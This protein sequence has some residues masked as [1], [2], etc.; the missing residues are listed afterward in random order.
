MSSLAPAS[1]DDARK[2]LD[3]LLDLMV[4][5]RASDMHLSEGCVPYLRVEGV[6]RPLDE[7]PDYSVRDL[8]C[9]IVSERQRRIFDEL[10]SLD[11]AYSRRQTRYR[12]NVFQ[13]RG[14][15][16]VAIR[17][18]ENEF[19][20]LDEWGL[21]LQLASFA[22]LRDGLVIVTGPTGSGKTT[23]LA[24]LIHE[25]NLNRSC[26]IVTIEDPLE[27]VHDNIH[28]LVHQREV[29]TD[30][31]DFASAVRASLRED[32]DVIL[33]GEMRD[34]ETARAAITAAET[35]HLVFSTLHTGDTVGAIDRLLG[36]FSGAEREAVAHQLSLALR[37]VVAQ[38]L[39]PGLNHGARVPAVEILQVTKAV[40]HLVRVGKWE[41]IYSAIE[42]GRA[43]GMRSFE[44][45]LRE[46]VENRLIAKEEAYRA[47]RDPGLLEELLN[48]GRSVT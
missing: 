37:A 43:E 29:H 30:V 12:I 19:R 8:A 24:T 32:P 6:L 17:R 18:L 42:T 44:Q 27:Y 15:V 48:S 11:F 40:A 14:Q 38:R 39:L 46:L 16:A 13:E 35:G 3:G 31:P 26:H 10:Q 21:P 28:S 33:V 2:A 7:K 22:D 4:A 45:S 47:T 34:A 5:R 1:S 36:I 20:T 25:I 23:T 9:S 41:Q